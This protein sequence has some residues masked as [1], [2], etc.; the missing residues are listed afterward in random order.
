ML[1]ALD[2]KLRQDSCKQAAHKQRNNNRSSARVHVGTQPKRSPENKGI[3]GKE[4]REQMQRLHM[5][6]GS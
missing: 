4:P 3:L 6:K 1:N 5:G 2:A